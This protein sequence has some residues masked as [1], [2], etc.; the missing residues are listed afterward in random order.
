MSTTDIPQ[1]GDW[2]T[3]HAGT[4]WQVL[5]PDDWDDYVHLAAPADDAELKI[6]TA[7]FAALIDAGEFEPTTAPEGLR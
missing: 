7:Q 4:H 2:V 5:T 6:T 3:G 1:A